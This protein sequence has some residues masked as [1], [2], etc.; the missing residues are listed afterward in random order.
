MPRGWVYD[1]VIS[2]NSFLQS[3]VLLVLQ[4]VLVGNSDVYPARPRSY[5]QFCS[6]FRRQRGYRF[7]RKSREVNKKD[8]FWLWCAL[9]AKTLLNKLIYSCSILPSIHQTRCIRIKSCP[10]L[11]RPFH[12]PYSFEI[13]CSSSYGGI[14]QV[15]PLQT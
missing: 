11:Q 10:L 8:G 15:V 4:Q 7:H 14:Y 3:S 9:I 6:L 13:Y 5:L 12:W 2:D 1:Q